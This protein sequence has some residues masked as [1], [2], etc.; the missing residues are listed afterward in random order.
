MAF[1]S[2]K[3]DLNCSICLNVYTDPV[4]LRCGHNFCRDCIACTLHTQESSGSYSCPECRERFV[5]RPALQRNITLCNIV[6]SFLSTQP[7]EQD[8]GIFCTYCVDSPAPAIKSCLLCE[9]SLCGKHLSVHKKSSEHV[10]T[11]PIASPESK[12]CSIH[13]KI[14]E[15]YCIQDAVCVCVSCTLA[16]DHKGHDV[17]LM[18]VAALKMKMKL[19][20]NLDVL[21]LNRQ[22][23]TKRIR[24][25]QNYGKDVHEKAVSSVVALVDLFRDLRKWLDRLEKNIPTMVYRQD[26]YLSLLISDQIQQLKKRKDEL[27]IKIC[28]VKQLYDTSDPLTVLKNQEVVASEPPANE[29]CKEETDN[30][31]KVGGLDLILVTAIL[32]T[33]MDN[34]GARLKSIGFDLPQTSSIS[35]DVD[36]A[37]HDVAISEDLRM[38]SWMGVSQNRL[39]M[40]KAFQ[41]CQVL[42][43]NSIS[44]GKHYW[45]MESSEVGDWCVG[46]SYSSIQRRGKKCIIGENDKSWGLRAWRKQYSFIH[47]S[48]V[49]Q[50]PSKVSCKKLGLCLDYEAGKLTFYELSIPLRCLYTLTASFT[51]PLHV[52]C[53][54]LGSW[55]RF[56]E[57]VATQQYE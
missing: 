12:K 15:Y 17:E 22:D 5:E 31:H 54:V 18:E 56:S 1:C 2:L 43:V 23:F 46:V 35:L 38:A 14:L 55:V 33:T 27:S 41:S 11:D 50:L 47:N 8:F 24:T 28:D 9:A 57:R 52:L 40:P 10:L 16:G 29:A 37:G 6:E 30:V 26:E 39:Q 34:F 7:G 45:E 44:S 25:L 42:S 48:N 49:I 19:K 20:D 36:T 51:E 32:H 21:I 53:W 13:K 3:E 4:T